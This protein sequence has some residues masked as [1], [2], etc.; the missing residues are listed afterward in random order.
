MEFGTALSVKQPM[1]IAVSNPT[2]STIEDQAI[3]SWTVHLARSH[4]ARTIVSVA[5]ICFATAAGCLAVGP[6]VAALV[7]AALTASLADY[8][9]PVRYVIT[10][11][12]ASCKSL[13]NRAEIRWADVKRCYLDNCGVKL[14]PLDR[15]SRLEAFRG[16]YLRFASNKDEVIETVKSLRPA[17]V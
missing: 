3:L 13:L 6:Y 5:F 2:S 7:A 15:V 1:P 14:S 8:L 4:P 12:K 10:R 17:D 11:D 9:F 16:V